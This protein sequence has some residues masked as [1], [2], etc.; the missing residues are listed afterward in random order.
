ML[1][2]IKIMDSGAV[3]CLE[4]LSAA[5]MLP[6]VLGGLPPKQTGYPAW[7]LKFNRF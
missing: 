7:M 2:H 4:G 1:P 5:T 3:A 6:S